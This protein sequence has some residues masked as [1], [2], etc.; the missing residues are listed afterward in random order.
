MPTTKISGKPAS[1]KPGPRKTVSPDL[2]SRDVAP[3]PLV[4]PLARTAKGKRPR[5]FQD[6][7]TDRLQSMVI[8]LMAELSVTRDRVDTLERLI[9]KAGLLSRS[10]IESYEP[11]A[12]AE[13]ER[14]QTRRAYIAR[15][16]KPLAHELD[17]IK[18]QSGG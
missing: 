12:D 5:Y 9:D 11:D 1:K 16:M 14:G 8:A 6:P 4:R 7:A 2:S 3:I 18:A 15:I 17:E 13:L 10:Q